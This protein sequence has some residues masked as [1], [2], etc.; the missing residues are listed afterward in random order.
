MTKK[1]DK[2][3]EGEVL[4]ETI[5]AMQ[6]IVITRTGESMQFFVDPTNFAQSMNSSAPMITFNCV[7]GVIRSFSPA[8]I[9]RIEAK[10]TSLRIEPASTQG[11]NL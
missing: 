10:K 9:S 1:T 11:E 6:T 8:S 2:V 7:D 5:P 3:I 4:V